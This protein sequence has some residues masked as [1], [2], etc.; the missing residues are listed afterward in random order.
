MLSTTRV[1]LNKPP[2]SERYIDKRPSCAGGVKVAIPMPFGSTGN[3]RYAQD[4]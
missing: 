4:A 1:R 3:R 2:L